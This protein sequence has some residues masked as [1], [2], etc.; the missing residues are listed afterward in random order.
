MLLLL[1][2]SHYLV[3]LWQP[4]MST[5]SST[6]AGSRA[7]HCEQLWGIFFLATFEDSQGQA[8]VLTALP[9]PSRNLRPSSPPHSTCSSSS[10]NS[11]TACGMLGWTPQ[12]PLITT[13]CGAVDHQIQHH[14]NPAGFGRDGHWWSL[15]GQSGFKSPL[16]AWTRDFLF[17]GQC[18]D[19]DST[20]L[21]CRNSSRGH[22]LWS[23]RCGREVGPQC[24]QLPRSHH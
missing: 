3:S 13:K 19:S 11:A 15:L 16:N 5:C 24:L 9:L 18:G 1:R 12:S 22:T 7:A 17:R 20:S 4:G 6:M 2:Q 23:V 8:W 10:R 21:P 14:P